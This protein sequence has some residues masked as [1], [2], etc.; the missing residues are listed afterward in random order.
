ML[1]R[2]YNAGDESDQDGVITNDKFCLSRLAR[3]TLNWSRL[4]LRPCRTP[5]D[6]LAYA[7]DEV[8]HRGA[9]HETSME[10]SAPGSHEGDSAR[11]V[12]LVNNRGE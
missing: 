5:T 7:P 6:H 2:G 10:S 1:S 12:V 3:L 4:Y 11:L 9:T 8:L